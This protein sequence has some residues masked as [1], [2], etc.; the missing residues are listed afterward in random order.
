LSGTA[1]V[2]SDSRSW[3]IDAL[4]IFLLAAALVAPL[5]KLKYLDNWASIESTFISDGRMLADNLPHR[6]WQP[7]WY[8]GTRS[9]YI[10]PPALRYGT[11]LIKKAIGSTAARAYHLYI[12]IFYAWGILGVYLMTRAGSGSRKWAWIAAASTALISP[13]FLLIREIRNDTIHFEPQRLHVLITY[14]EGPHMTALAWLPFAFAGSMLAF[15]GRSWRWAFVAGLC[16]AAVVANNFYGATALALL[17]PMLVWAFFLRDRSRGLLAIA[18]AIPLIAFG[19]CA[20]WLTPSYL[21]VTMRNLSLVSEPGNLPSV[22]AFAMLMGLYA[23]LSWRRLRDAN[24]WTLFVASSAGL[25]CFYILGRRWLH[26][27]IAGETTRLY[28]ELDLVLI[29]LAVE[30]LRRSAVPKWLSHAGAALLILPGLYYAKDAWK[31]IRQD[32]HWE[33]RLEYKITGWIHENLPGKRVFVTGSTRFWFNAWFDHAQ[34][35][36]GSQQGLLNYHLVP[37]QY[38]MVSPDTHLATLWFRALGADA[39]VVPE[40][41]SAEIYHDIGKPEAWHNGPLP[42]IH[43]IER[44]SIYGVPRRRSGIVRLVDRARLEG[45]GSMPGDYETPLLEKYVEAIEAVPVGGADDGRVSLDWLGTDAVRIR[46]TVR[47]GEAV[48]FQQ[49]FDPCWKIV[50]GPPGAR[51][52]EDPVGFQRIELPP[53]SHDLR[54]VFQTPA[55]VSVGRFLTIVTLITGAVVFLRVQR[56][57]Q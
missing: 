15:R 33:S 1:T 37:A 22:I 3:W 55:E 2:R 46:A 23:T 47:D 48:L 34:V 13:S 31:V 4:A 27:Q 53:G 9:D 7:Y 32:P 21:R 45:I 28:P 54:L 41:D 40:R 19:L 57:A 25:M 50:D 43:E 20:S 30:L 6:H 38:R 18:V 24:G 49:S 12:G 42:K 51:I 8:C 35:D 16:A 52:V 29:L 26:V 17:Y 36:G 44:N 14:G 11:A 10:Y 5:F 39:V 56:K